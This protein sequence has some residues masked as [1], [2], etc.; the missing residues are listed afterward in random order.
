GALN[1]TLGGVTQGVTGS[2]NQVLDGHGL[3]LSGVTNGGLAGGLLSGDGSVS[4]SADSAQA[5]LHATGALA[6]NGVSDLVGQVTHAPD[7]T[8]HSSDHLLGIPLL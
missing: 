8:D 3:D 7:A 5:S 1:S 6:P 2:V 4:T